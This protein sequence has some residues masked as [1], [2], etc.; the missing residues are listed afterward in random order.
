[1]TLKFKTGI[2]AI[3]GENGVGKSSVVEGILFV[4][5]G[6]LFYGTKAEAIKTGEDSGYVVLGFELNGKKGKLTRHLDVSSTNLVYDG[7]TYKKS[8]DVKELWDRLLQIS[9]EIVERVIIAKQ[10]DIPLLFSGDQTVREKIFQKIFLVPNTE[11]IRNTLFKNYIKQCPPV[12]PLEDIDQLNL[13]RDRLETEIAA[14]SYELKNLVALSEDQVDKVKARIIYI[15]R[16]NNDL[17]KI[18]QTKEALEQ[19]EA[20]EHTTL[21]EMAECKEVLG[22]IRVVDYEKQYNTQLQQKSLFEQKKKIDVQLAGL[23]FPFSELQYT[24][25]KAE[26]KKLEDAVH[27][28]DIKLLEAKINLG[29][30][31]QQLDHFADLHGKTSCQTCG[32]ALDNIIPLID[33]LQQDKADIELESKRTRLEHIEQSRLLD[34]IYGEIQ[35]YESTLQLKAQLETSKQHFSEL[36]FDEEELAFCKDVIDQYRAYEKNLDALKLKL[37]KLYSRSDLFKQ[38]L[39][40]LA[41]YDGDDMLAER[42]QLAAMLD[43]HAEGLR[44]Y[45]T[46]QVSLRVKQFELKSILERIATNEKNKE[47]NAKRNL[48][49]E[50][51]N[52]AHDVLHSSNFPR[53]L[54]L[55]YADDVTEHLQEQLDNFS[56]PYKARVA[57]NFKIEMIDKNNH[58]LPGVSG[59]QEIQVG[60]SLHLALHTL[61]SQSFP[62]MIIDEGTTHLDALNRRAYFNLIKSMKE[63]KKIKQMIL[64]DHDPD[65][66]EVV[67]N[68]IEIKKN[69]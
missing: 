29:N 40:S 65:I 39:K 1:M 14:L 44:L 58:V 23:Q 59:G 2:T 54:I 37:A 26:S 66:I 11:R 18:A 48:Y 21:A 43:A 55:D 15:N 62:L 3:V 57:D 49:H 38:Q 33:K 61:F 10:G 69:A 31:K 24:T 27:A 19:V 68:I 7:I 36:S 42:E 4:T 60:I 41:V 6:K 25:F 35:Q 5:T 45:Q 63:G 53:K 13:D 22:S 50:V 47:K 34:E 51:L 20:E 67:D 64:I 9:S 46:K 32:Q 17:E 12:I 30:V 56:I 16:C 52:Q 8:T 28:L